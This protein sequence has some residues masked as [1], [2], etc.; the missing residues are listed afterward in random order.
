MRGLEIRLNAW[1]GISQRSG[2]SLDTALEIEMIFRE[3]FTFEKWQTFFEVILHIYSRREFS[4]EK[5]RLPAG[6]P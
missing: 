4:V 2:I 5:H 3:H 1:L 6:K